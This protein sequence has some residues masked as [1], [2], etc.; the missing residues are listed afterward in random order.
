[1]PTQD[2]SK[3]KLGEARTSSDAHSDESNNKC[4]GDISLTP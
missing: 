2:K 4:E 1:V 3:I